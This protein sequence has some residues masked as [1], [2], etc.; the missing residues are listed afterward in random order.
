MAKK[1]YTIESITADIEAFKNGKFSKTNMTIDF[2]D[3]YVAKFQP[4]TINQWV[5]KCY[6]MPMIKRKIGGNEREIKDTKAIREYFI[7]TYFPDFTE[8]AIKANKEA[9]KAKKKAEKELKEAEK[10]LS[11]KDKFIAKMKRLSSE[12]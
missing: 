10:N 4:N 9:K 11:D 8:D 6:S 2:M 5:E 7:A 1:E 12:K 3:N